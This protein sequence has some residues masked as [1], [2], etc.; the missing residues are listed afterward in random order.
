MVTIQ[1]ALESVSRVTSAEV[2]LFLR[3]IRAAGFNDDEPADGVFLDLNPAKI[4][5]YGKFVPL[6]GKHQLIFQ[7]AL[8]LEVSR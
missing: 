3:H 1:Q 7:R 8:H 5:I 4:H 2:E 6:D